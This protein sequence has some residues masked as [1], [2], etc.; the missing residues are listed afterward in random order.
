MIYD[1]TSKVQQERAKKRLDYLIEKKKKIEITQKNHK[2]TLS[3]NNY[4][5]LIIDYFAVQIGL[6]RNEAKQY[7][8]MLSEDY[9]YYEKDGFT[10]VRSSKDLDK[11]KMMITIDRF[12]NHAAANGIDLPASDDVQ[13]IDEARNEI[14]RNQNYL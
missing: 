4:L 13:Y 9:Y 3:Q 8:K 11:N 2:R 10:Y 1:L 5:H 7:Y 6:T 14:E 12:V